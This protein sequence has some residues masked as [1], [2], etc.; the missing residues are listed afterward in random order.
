[1]I[2]SIPWI[3]IAFLLMGMGVGFA[4]MALLIWSF[5][6]FVWYWPRGK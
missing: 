3:S 1:M 5:R 4:G 2:N 6:T